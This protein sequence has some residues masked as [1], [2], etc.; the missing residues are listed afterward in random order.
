MDS[1]SYNA[2]KANLERIRLHMKRIEECMDSIPAK[3]PWYEHMNTEERVNAI[4][5]YAVKILTAVKEQS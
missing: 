4:K 3:H 1:P 2:T 5:E